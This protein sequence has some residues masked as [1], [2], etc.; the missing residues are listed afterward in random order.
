MEFAWLG[1]GAIVGYALG[2]IEAALIVGII[3]FYLGRA[4]ASLDEQEAE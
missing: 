1:L 2:G 4:L 3:A